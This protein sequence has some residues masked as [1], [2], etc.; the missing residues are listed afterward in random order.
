MGASTTPFTHHIVII[1]ASF[2][3]LSLAHRLLQKV[4]PA[5]DSSVSYKVSMISPNNQFY[6]NVAAPRQ[7]VNPDSLPQERIFLHLVPGFEKYGAGFEHVKAYATS[8]DSSSK[9]VSYRDALGGPAADT[10]HYDSLLGEETTKKALAA[11]HA[12]MPAA[13]SILIAGGG[14]TG[15]ETAGEL[16]WRY[17]KSK[18]I[19]LVSGG[20]KLLARLRDSRLG[21]DAEAML[22]KLG[23]QIVHGMKVHAEKR[24]SGGTTIRMSNGS[25]SV[26]DVFIDATGEHPNHNFIPKEWLNEYGFVKT[27]VST[28]RA[29]IPGIVN[30]YV[31]G[32][33]G[34]Y[35]DGSVA[36]V[37]FGYKAA[38]ESIRIDL[39]GECKNIVLLNL[40]ATLLRDMFCPLRHTP[41]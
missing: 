38:C 39:A 19:T 11:I 1:G 16:G 8:I 32:S 31:I 20:S 33:I 12:Q 23:V 27:H 35:S 6:W 13:S 18:E 2:G 29:D 24:H 14:P 7:I 4:I 10:V 34:S 22:K 17:G 30:T 25:E 3:G 5:L 28:L 26:V 9:T 41:S 37:L 21:A 40:M 36:S 15:V